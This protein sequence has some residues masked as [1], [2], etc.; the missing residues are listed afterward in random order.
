MGQI[1]LFPASPMRSA[2]APEPVE[3][4]L[5]VGVGA[6]FDLGAVPESLVGVCDGL[7]IRYLAEWELHAADLEPA[8]WVPPSLPS[9]HG[10]RVIAVTIDGEVI[11]QDR[12]GALYGGGDRQLGAGSLISYCGVRTQD[13]QRLNLGERAGWLMSR[14][15]AESFVFSVHISEPL[16]WVYEAPVALGPVGAFGGWMTAASQLAADAATSR[17]DAAKPSTDAEEAHGET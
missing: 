9:R 5:L 4:V 11:E 6:E 12:T 3:E 13:E 8:E 17:C 16:L 7:G 10:R 14:M 2:A 15:E 1:M